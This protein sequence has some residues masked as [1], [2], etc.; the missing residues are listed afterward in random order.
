MIYFKVYKFVIKLEV[1]LCLNYTQ[2]I[3]QLVTN[4]KQ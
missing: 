4:H 3:N 1:I 2:T